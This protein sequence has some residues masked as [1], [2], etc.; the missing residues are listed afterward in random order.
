MMRLYWQQYTADG[1][2]P[3]ASDVRLATP[4]AF[5]TGTLKVPDPIY[6]QRGIETDAT[7]GRAPKIEGE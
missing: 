5:T 7:V 4:V 1:V 2:M 6:V 3:A